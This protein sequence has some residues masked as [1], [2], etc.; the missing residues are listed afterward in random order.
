MPQDI[1]VGVPSCAPLLQHELLKE[2]RRQIPHAYA[3][4]GQEL[5]LTIDHTQEVIDKRVEIISAARAIKL[6][7]MIAYEPNARDV[8]S[9]TGYNLFTSL[10]QEFPFVV[11]KAI[12]SLPRSLRIRFALGYTRQIAHRFAGS[13]NQ[14]NAEYRQCGITLTVFDGLFSDRLDT[15]G[16]A[17]TFYRRVFE[18]MFR[19]LALVDC[20]VSEV[21]RSRVHLN[22]C[23]LEIAWEA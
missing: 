19:Q 3:R 20:E 1:C 22:Q 5:G 15:L 11:R 6:A 17:H 13:L 9:E 7:R 21:R 12:C 16:C 2:M 18:T 10:N 4:A 23:N 8:F 14:I